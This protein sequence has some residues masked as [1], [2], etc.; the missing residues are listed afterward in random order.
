MQLYSIFHAFSMPYRQI[1][2]LAPRLAKIGFTHVQFPPIQRTRQLCELDLEL[3]HLQLKAQD[4]QLR[5]FEKLCAAAADKNK[6]YAPHNFSYVLM[7]RIQY[8]RQPLLRDMHLS[9][10]HGIPSH[11]LLHHLYMNTEYGIAIASAAGYPID[12]SKCITLS[13]IL[14][15]I[16]LIHCVGK[17]HSQYALLEAIEL[18]LKWSP[19][20]FTVA[21][22]DRLN[23]LKHNYAAIQL[24]LRAKRTNT[25]VQKSNQIKKEYMQL[26]AK[27]K[28]HEKQH[29]ILTS[30][31]SLQ[32]TLHNMR[33][34]IPN[35]VPP[36]SLTRTHDPLPNLPIFDDKIAKV[37]KHWLDIATI[38]ELL[39]YGPWWLIYQPLELEIGDTLLGTGEDIEHAISACNAN[40]LQVIADVVVNNLAATAGEK[41][42]WK[43][44]APFPADAKTLADVE[45]LILPDT[46]Q[47]LNTLLEHAFGSADTSLVTAPYE[48]KKEQDPQLCWMSGAL[49]Q[50]NQSHPI[51]HRAVHTFMDQ[52]KWLGASGVRI[53][54]A[55]HLHPSVCNEITRKFSGLSYVEYVGETPQIYKDRLEDFAIGE[56]LYSHIFSEQAHYTRLKNYGGDKLSRVEDADSVVM[57][58]NHDHIMGSIRSQVFEKL[59]SEVTYELSVVYLI[60]RIYG[61][62]L[63]MPHDLEFL[64]VQKA[65][66][67]RNEMKTVGVTHENVIIN[68]NYICIEKYNDNGICF[69]VHINMNNDSVM[70]AHGMVDKYSFEYF[71]IDS[72]NACQ[73]FN[74]LTRKRNMR[75]RKAK[76]SQKV[77]HFQ[78][79]QQS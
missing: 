14:K 11:D 53:D 77:K 72:S 5:E 79:P 78:Q 46:I 66:R 74:R 18:V 69:I 1:A 2:E 73:V 63:L 60:Q 68:G 41:E 15:T 55:A 42:S 32:K 33:S 26:Q 29:T 51:I 62:V 8:I 17:S 40:G 75:T 36:L 35:I 59:P 34:S 27:H 6:K 13:P 56:D 50:L 16:A 4:L 21:D 65:L 45:H 22:M 19:T 67:L 9:L 28:H 43:S 39:V 71:A 23:E 24:Q 49:P 52:L 37:A 10:L 12:T 70:T 58:L 25:N 76:K 38:A 30:I 48:C 3:L 47:K 20:S 64:S 31:E 54:A 61:T 44:S 7:K 57:I